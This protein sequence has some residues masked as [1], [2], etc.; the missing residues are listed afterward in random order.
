MAGGRE[1]RHVGADLGH[2]DLGGA[3]LDPGD[4]AQQLNRRGER[5]KPLLDGL[6]EP[7]DLLV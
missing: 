5:A 2:D 3:R 1:R 4:G 7:L 6:R